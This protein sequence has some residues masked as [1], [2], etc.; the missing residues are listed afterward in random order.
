MNHNRRAAAKEVQTKRQRPSGNGSQKGQT[1]ADRA[2]RSTQPTL[3]LVICSSAKKAAKAGG[4]AAVFASGG[5]VSAEGAARAAK[6]RAIDQL[7]ASGQRHGESS[8]RWF[9]WTDEINGTRRGVRT[10]PGSESGKPFAQTA[11]MIS[12][13][14]KR[15]SDVLEVTH[16]QSRDPRAAESSRNVADRRDS[17]HHPSKTSPQHQ[18]LRRP[19]TYELNVQLFTSEDEDDLTNPPSKRKRRAFTIHDKIEILDFAKKTSIHAASKQFTIARNTMRKD[20]AIPYGLPLLRQR[21]QEKDM[22]KLV[23]EID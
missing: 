10:E 20:G 14:V 18:R 13:K 4:I 17:D 7:R 23:E 12:E 9:G 8:D 21:R 16:G 22:I 11:H 19:S 6:R 1:Y 5:Q 15:M 2:R 3:L